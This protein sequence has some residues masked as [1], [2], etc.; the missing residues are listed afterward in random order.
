M[1]SFDSTAP[2]TSADD[3]VSDNR[4]LALPQLD[5]SSVTALVVV[6]AHPDDESLGAGGL[7]ADCAAAGIPVTVLIVTDGGASHPDSTVITV[8]QLTERRRLE[9]RWAVAALDPRATLVQLG[10][11]DGHTLDY[12]TS[13]TA[14]LGGLIPPDATIVC[15]WRGDGHRDHRIVGEICAEIAGGRTLLEYP[16]WLWHWA[17]PDDESVPWSTLSRHEL[18]PGARRAKARAVAE[19]ATQ[20]DALGD[21]AGDGPVLTAGFLQH[22]DRGHEMFVV[23]PRTMP[24]DYFDRLYEARD[25]P[26]RLATRWY[27][28]RKRAI[29][30]A[31][32]PDERYGRALEVGCSIG[33][34]TE[35]LAPRCESLL[36]IDLSTAA[37]ELARERVAGHPHVTVEVS[38]A[39]ADFPPGP[40]DLI[41]LSEV[42]YYFSGAALAA[43]LDTVDQH[44][45]PGGTLLACHW[46]HAVADYPLDGDE[47]QRAVLAIPGLTVLARHEEEDFS[48]AVLSRDDRS[49]ARREGLL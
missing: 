21:E 44:L 20:V 43:L 37:V 31:S 27:E 39:A 45:A 35:Q 46:R 30:V 17:T 48:L 25:D 5:L 3:W 34:L 32:L 8:D 36:A 19:Y 24:A 11:P 29:T 7:I 40:F 18:S 15:P 6:A 42:G 13:I 1:V 47:V 9:V 26:W 14:D 23:S 41:V 10:Y 33:V 12:R 16:I 22:F 49:V 38:D 28:T 4:M 2:G